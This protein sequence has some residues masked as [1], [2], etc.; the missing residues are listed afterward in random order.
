M[1]ESNERKY[2]KELLLHIN[3]V[4]SVEALDSNQ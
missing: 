2:E 4:L 1:K 3:I